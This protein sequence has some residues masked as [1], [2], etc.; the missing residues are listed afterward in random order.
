LTHE[1]VPV[2]AHA[3]T[4]QLVA[5]PTYPSSAVP[6]QFSSMPL[7]VVSLAAGVPG[8]QLLCSTPLTHELVPVLAHAPTPQVVVCPTYPSS[9]VPL[10]FSSIPLQVVSLGPGVPG[11]H[12]WG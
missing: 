1:D 10:Q 12:V 9:A 4:P 7:Q 5:C 6:L 2:L 11:V 3:P 8:V